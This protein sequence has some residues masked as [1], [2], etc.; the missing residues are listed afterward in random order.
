MKRG[1][2]AHFVDFNIIILTEVSM[3]VSNHHKGKRQSRQANPDFTLLMI[4]GFIFALFYFYIC[5]LFCMK[6]VTN[7]SVPALTWPLVEI[8]L[9]C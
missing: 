8:S 5:Y 6:S 7:S 1:G 3:K 2:G 9:L 4:H